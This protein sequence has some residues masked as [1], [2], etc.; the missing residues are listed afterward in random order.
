[1]IEISLLAPFRSKSS[2]TTFVTANSPGWPIQGTTIFDGNYKNNIPQKSITPTIQSMPAPLE[3]YGRIDKY[4]I[5]KE[6]GNKHLNRVFLVQMDSNKFASISLSVVKTM[7]LSDPAFNIETKIFSL[8]LHP[9]IITCKEILTSAAIEVNFDVC[10]RNAVVLD[11]AVNGDLFP[12]LE[13]GPLREKTS[14]FYFGQLIDAIDHLHANGYCHLDVKPENLLLDEKFNFKLSD[15]GFAAPYTEMLGSK[16]VYSQCGTSS[17]TPPELWKQRATDKGYDGTKADIFQCGILLFIMLTGQPPFS[18][19]DM[20]DGWFSLIARGRWDEFW[21]YKE[22]RI[23]ESPPSTTDV[24]TFSADLR[25]LFQQ[26]FEPQPDKR[27]TI[28]D[29]KNSQWYTQ[30]LPAE[31]IEVQFEMLS[32]KLTRRIGQK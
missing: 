29:I 28:Q 2:I 3:S 18:K 13:C 32:R 23:S 15:F 24:Q 12:Y 8:P 31:T 25:K 11:H 20:K 9:N 22:R 27:I 26:I 14:R 10:I 6:F 5:L 17:Y 30:T 1:M 21:F 19:S 4:K 7:N 16:L